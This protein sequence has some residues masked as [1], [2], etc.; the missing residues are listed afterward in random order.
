MESFFNTLLIIVLSFFLLGYIMRLVAPYII[1]WYTRRMFHK[2]EQF[3][4]TIFQ[5]P[6]ESQPE[7]K[8][9]NK[10]SPPSL[11]NVGDYVDFEEINDK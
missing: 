8:A 11:D 9:D 5:Q 1:R 10:K 2:F 7:N 3:H 4:Q 6:E